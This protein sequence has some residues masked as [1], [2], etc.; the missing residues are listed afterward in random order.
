LTTNIAAKKQKFKTNQLSDE[1]FKQLME[2]MGRLFVTQC[3]L[4]KVE[5]G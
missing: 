4:E 5:E 3:L 1:G 2:E